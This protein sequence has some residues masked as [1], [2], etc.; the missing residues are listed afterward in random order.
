[1]I[2]IVEI[3]LLPQRQNWDDVTDPIAAD[4]VNTILAWAWAQHSLLEAVRRAYRLEDEIETNSVRESFFQTVRLWVAGSSF[5]TM[6]ERSNLPVDD[7]L[8]IYAATISFELQT[9]VEQGVAL[10][11]KLLEAQGRLLSPAVEQFP[12]HLRF[13]VPSP[14]ARVLAAD[15]V[16]HRRAAVELGSSD[17]LSGIE[18]GDRRGVFAAAQRVLLQD[19]GAFRASLGGLMFEQTR[20]DLVNVT[21]DNA[22]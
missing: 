18:V 19:Q 7:L 15:A 22:Q 1:M 8:G 3:G 16:R 10:L 21:R 17:T 4:L 13:G 14:A 12:E 11:K 9:L 2:D 5:R 20:R 6:A